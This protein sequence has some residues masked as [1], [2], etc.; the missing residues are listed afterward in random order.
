M[1]APGPDD[2]LPYDEGEYSVLQMPDAWHVL[3]L[4][5]FAAAL[6]ARFLVA[7]L[8]SGRGLFYRPILTAFSVP[9][10]AT[11]GLLFG[12]VGLRRPAT[13][14]VARI[15]VLLNLIVLGL[16]AVAIAAFYYILPG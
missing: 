6:G 10:L 9:V 16:S 3:S 11:V 7:F 14:G 12:L 2:P 1:S 4:A 5:F 15:A 8:P 13:R